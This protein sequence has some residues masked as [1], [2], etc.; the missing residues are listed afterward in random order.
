LHIL[1]AIVKLP[2][3]K[4]TEALTTVKL[5]KPDYQQA[6]YQHTLYVNALRHCGVEV[7]LLEPDNRFPDS[8][9]VEDTA[10]LTPAGAV[11]T[12]PG[13]PSRRGETAEI[14]TTLSLLYNCIEHI[15]AP[16]TLDAGD[17]LQVEQHYYIGLSSRTNAEGAAQLINILKGFGLSGSTVPLRKMFHLKSGVSYL[18]NN[19]LVTAGE[20][21]NHPQFQEFRQIKVSQ[22]ESYAANCLW[23]N[24]KVLVAA[25]YPRISE[26]IQKAGFEVIELEMSE[27]RK[28]DGG[29]SCLS[30]RF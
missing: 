19:Y 18:Q 2:C 6:L 27:F 5:G 23:L 1:K 26:E 25:G 16:G 24:G 9:F 3:E 20:F 17:I 30:L 14:E 10:L 29:L 28:I 21:I 8:T 11:M 12:R 13:A 15:Q 22:S 4:I 7:T